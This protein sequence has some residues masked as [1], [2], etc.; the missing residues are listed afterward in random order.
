MKRLIF[1]ASIFL[2]CLATVSCK[3]ETSSGGGSTTGDILIGHY[4]S[5]SGSEATFGLSTSRGIKL[6]I[7]ELNAS[8]G[9]NGR[10]VVLKEYDDKG[11]SKEA[12]S[13][14]TRLVTNDKVVAVLG[15]VSSGL[16]L[17]GAPICQDGGVPMI[18]PSSTNERVTAAGD[19]IFRVCFIDDFQGYAGAKFAYDDRKARKA[20]VLFDQASPYSKGLANFSRSTS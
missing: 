4:G 14:V 7:K 15:E 12:G 18:S 6:A 8:G 3:K 2:A 20:A 10:K 17:A 13:V 16:S 1:S 5:L 11:D 9:I 19:M